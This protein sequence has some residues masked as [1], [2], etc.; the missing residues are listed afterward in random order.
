MNNEIRKMLNNVKNINLF[1]KIE[2]GLVEDK[3][4]V[5]KF[6]GDNTE[7]RK[8]FIKEIVFN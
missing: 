7:E 3:E 6:D 1:E 8:N 2:F 5:I 4:G